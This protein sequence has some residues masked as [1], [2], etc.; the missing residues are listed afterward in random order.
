MK[1][2]YGKKCKSLFRRLLWAFFDNDSSF[3]F[4]MR[5]TGKSK[6]GKKN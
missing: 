5:A 2:I 1:F 4:F 6:N 3:V